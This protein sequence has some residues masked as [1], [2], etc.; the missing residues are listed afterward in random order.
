[1]SETVKKTRNNLPGPGPGRP[2]GSPNKT[3]QAVK[4]AIAQAAEDLGGAQRL[5]AWAKEDP[6]NERAFWTTIYPKL[7][8]LQ[9]TGEDG[10]PVQVQPILN[11]SIAAN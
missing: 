9:L 6:A 2:K 10:G 1:M 4:D 11:V 5:V 7:L 8:P 3:T